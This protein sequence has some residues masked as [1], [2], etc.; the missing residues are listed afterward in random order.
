MWLLV[1]LVTVESVSCRW[2]PLCLVHLV[3][4]KE[5]ERVRALFEEKERERVRER[6]RDRDTTT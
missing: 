6:A 5:R 4:E 1:E 2:F 3:E